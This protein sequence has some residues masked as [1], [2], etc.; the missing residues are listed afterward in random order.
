VRI[1][2]IRG[3]NLASL[4]EFAIDF[5]A[6]PLSRSGL[7]AITGQT[8]SG[9]STILDALCV[10]LFDMTPRLSDRGG[11]LIGRPDEDDSLKLASNDVRSLLRRGTGSGSAQVDFVGRDGRSYRASWQVRRARNAPGGKFQP[12]EIILNDLETGQPL[13][14][15][16][17]ETLE[18]IQEK[19]GLTYDQFRRS[20]LLA[21]GEFA[22][23]L[24]AD[25]KERA[26]LLE[27]ITGTDIYGRLSMAAFN[28]KKEEERKLEDLNR[29]LG[30]L[31]LMGDEERAAVE[32]SCRRITD[33]IKAARDSLAVLEKGSAWYRRRKELS[34]AIA[35]A[36]RLFAS[37]HSDS[38]NALPLRC[39][40]AEAEA[41]E[42]FRPLVSAAD[43]TANELEAAIRN[44][45]ELVGAV[46]G[47]E[48]EVSRLRL[49]LKDAEAIAANAEKNLAEGRPQ[50]V[51][52][53]D[54]DTRIAEASR[55]ISDE[56]KQLAD[57]QKETETTAAEKAE[58]D[59]TVLASRQEVCE[60]D[61]WFACH[62]EAGPVAVEWGR[63]QTELGRFAVADRKRRDLSIVLGKASAGK[64][65]ADRGLQAAARLLEETQL[66]A[67]AARESVTAAELAASRIDLSEL[68]LRR[69]EQ[70]LRLSAAN[71]LLQA[72]RQAKETAQELAD[73]ER[74][75][76]QAE[77]DVRCAGERQQALA[78][79]R[80]SSAAALAEADRSHALARASLELADHRSELISGEPCPLCGS[81]DHPYVTDG[82]PAE[83]L[84]TVLKGRV[85]ELQAAITGLERDIAAG[86]AILSARE[87]D[88][89]RE[90]LRADACR[91]LLR[92]IG[93]QWEEARAVLTG[94]PLPD[95]ATGAEAEEA[96]LCL[97]RE[98]A[99][100][101]E[102]LK[103]EEKKGGDLLQA[104]GPAREVLDKAQKDRD[105]ARDALQAAEGKA[106]T[107]QATVE[108]VTGEL[109]HEES[110][111]AEVLLLLETPL[112]GWV[113]WREELAADPASFTDRCT[114]LVGECL[115]WEERKAKAVAK[116]SEA[117]TRLEAVGGRLQVLSANL[118]LKEAALRKREGDAAALT[119]ERSVFWSGRP[120]A[121]EELELEGAADAARKKVAETAT[122]LGEAE[123]RCASV[124][125]RRDA[126]TAARI[127]A[128]AARAKGA[129]ELIAA[130]APAGLDEN[131]L[132]ETLELGEEW[133]TETRGRLIVLD[134][135]LRDAATILEERRNGLALHEEGERPVMTEEAI[136][137]AKAEAT[138]RIEA[139]DQALIVER[140]K[141]EADAAARETAGSLRPVITSQ[142]ERTRLWQGMNELIGSGDGKKF[143][144]FAQS[145]TLD[146]LLSMANGHLQSLAPRFAV[147]RVPSSEMELQMVDRDMGDDI[148][149]VNNIS[150]GE[151]FLVSL[152]LALGLSSLASGATRIGSL[153][154][155]E[156][157]GSLDQD[158]LDVA[159]STLDALQASGRMVG[160]ISH[161]AGLTERIGTRIEVKPCG[162]GRSRVQVKGV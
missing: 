39:R 119:A 28:R 99:G 69:Q 19:I 131:N 81:P 4:P 1:L 61:S 147:M 27:K 18:L 113:G 130:I 110:R 64:T 129:D 143:R 2:A 85:T 92:K 68:R 151:S 16:K 124:A 95:A 82:A 8:G 108:T 67:D 26:E 9:K 117:Q 10:A 71:T 34:D 25:G 33:D 156:G 101:L 146:I 106:R 53:R 60:A 36:E 49:A 21:Q 37:A 79:E 22:A 98:V 134:G 63:W 138:T 29:R 42:K 159:L 88:G 50:F 154:I 107:I 122:A 161:V 72:A 160:V 121:D 74:Q 32:A 55:L 135:A 62:R 128:E 103:A 59:K 75:V 139:L 105:A 43:R 20:V 118:T 65:A 114:S 150:G 5:T 80:D 155:D 132:R 93:I 57:L 96:S 40:L 31:K 17:S 46:A 11:A 158:T 136:T 52:A 111:A 153:F 144:S 100:V 23:F 78:N 47:A 104:L 97:S 73:T 157:F 120:V 86:E 125:G 91:D 162:G 24:R 3:S 14:S 123:P 149:S 30:D 41:A 83:N 35:E 13:G 66:E 51:A 45:A 148:R 84:A 90:A 58:F 152:S 38:D 56:R 87:Q 145:L 141:L 76:E 102:T 109:H 15:K 44:E 142:E 112:A 54:L 12:Q 6:E 126:A 48:Q 140:I 89:K 77:S 127:A 116:E 7:F 133:L 94:E 115:A 137:P 70:E